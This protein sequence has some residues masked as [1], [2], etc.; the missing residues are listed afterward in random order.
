MPGRRY[1]FRSALLASTSLLGGGGLFAGSAT[2]QVA[3]PTHGVV[4]SGAASIKQS[5]A[6]LTID[7][8]TP[9][10]IINWNS[11]SIGQ[12]ASVTVVQPNA[13]SAQLDRVTGATPSTI[14]GQLRATGQVY[15]VNPNG[16]AITSSGVVRVGGGFVASTLGVTN[17]DF[18]RGVL[19]FSGNGASAAVSNAGSISTAPGGFVGLLGGS[20]SN[21]G[22]ITVP[23]G[24]VG[25]GSGEQATLDPTGDGFLQV[26]VPTGAT[27]SDGTALVDVSGKVS[28][29]GGRV[30]LK[31]ATAAGA[32]R[33]A[34]NLSGVVSATSARV[35]GG[36]IILDGGAGGDV[37]VSGA[38]D[39]SGRTSGGSVRI[40][41][42]NVAL[43]KAK[44]AAVGKTGAGGTITSTAA[45]GLALIGTS[46]NASGATRGGV[47]AIGGDRHGA[48][49]LAN[50]ATTSVDA[51][52]MLRADALVS[53]N[54]GTITVWS[55]T[56]TSFAGQISARGGPQGGDGGSAE[57]SA[58]AATHGV[59]SFT[60]LADLRAP[61]GAVGTLLL[62]P[63]DIVISAGADAGGYFSG[64]TGG[65]PASYTPTATSVINAST[66][67]GL[68]ASA[69]VVV[70]TG[71]AGSAG[72]DA[73]AITALAPL[74]W[75]T[76]NGLTLTAAGAIS[77]DSSI[78]A[79]AGG[80][81]LSA[82]GAISATGAISVGTFVLESGAWSQVTPTL[83]AFAS[84]DFEIASGASFLR[85]TG[86]DGSTAHPYTLVDIY[87]VQ[88]VASLLAD[89]F[90]LA[91]NIDATVT[92]TWNAGAGFIPIGGGEAPFIGVFNGAGH[93]IANLTINQASGY[94]DVGLFG[95]VGDGSGS[96]VVENIGLIGGSV[97]ASGS[98]PYVGALIG[99]NEGS[100]TNGYALGVS[101]SGP[102]AGPTGPSG[103]GGLVG[104]NGGS[105]TDSYATGAITS[106]V[107]DVGGL[108]GENFGTVTSS[109]AKGAVSGAGAGIDVGGLVG[110]NV[111]TIASS[112]ATGAVVGAGSDAFVGGLVGLNNDTDGGGGLVE[113]SFAAG[114]V[115]GSGAG[116]AVGGL[117]GENYFS[118]RTSYAT[119]AVSASGAG[120]FVGGLVG[121]DFGTVA[122]SYWDTQT[123][124]QPTSAGGSGAT[125]L[126]TS[127]LQGALPTG[128]VSVS[129]WATGAGLYPYLTTSFPTGVQAISGF[130]YK[131]AAGATPLASGAA[132]AAYVSADASGVSFGSAT[133]GANG[134][135][136]LFAAKG[137]APSGAD[138]IAYTTADATTGATN[139][140]T[141]FVSAGASNASGNTIDGS[142]LTETTPSL[143]YSGIAA[144]LAS[145]AGADTAALAAIAGAVNLTINATGAS[146][147]VDEAITVPGNLSIATAI[148]TGPTLL[149]FAVKSTGGD[150]TFSDAV[151]VGPDVTVEAPTG[152]VTFG[153][154]VDGDAVTVTGVAHIGGNIT[155]AN[156]AITFSDAIILDA[157][158][159]LD[160]GTATMTFA[161]AI[162]S[163]AGD[164]ASKNFDLTATAGSFSFGGA[165]GATDALGAVSLTSTGAMSLPSISA[166]TIVA[167][168]TG[169]SADLTLKSGSV[170]TASVADGTA[171]TL[172]AG[173]NFINDAGAGAIDLSGAGDPP[174]WVIYAASPTGSSFGGL[175]SGNHAIW[176]TPSGGVVPA[177]GNYYV[178]AFQPTVTFT[179]TNHTTTYSP[180]D[181][182]TAATAYTVSG[183]Q[184]GVTGAYLA[185]T[186]AT[187]YSGAPDVTLLSGAS[188]SLPITPGA[189][190]SAGAYAI[191]LSA[192]T[193]ASASGYAF[194]FVS[195]GSLAVSPEAITITAAPNTKIYDSTTSAA[196]K[197][198]VTSGTLYDTATLTETYA[199]P[200]AGTG[201]TLTP[202]ATI[203]GAANYVVTLVSESTGVIAP[204]PI[205]ITVAPNS[206]TYDGATTAA[207]TPTVTSGTLYDPA[208]L[209]ESYV[210]PNAGAGLELIATATIS[211]AANYTVTLASAYDGVITPE[212][213]TI[214]AAPN[215]K[216]YDSMTSAAATPT[217]TSGTLYDP[218]TLAETYAS[219]NAGSGLTLTPTAAIVGA[220]NYTVTL[221]AENTG[222]I[223][224]EPITITAA[225]NTKIYDSTTSAAA[226][227]TVTAG[228]LYDPATLAETYA[229]A[230]AGT[231]LTLTPTAAISGAGNYTVTI[232]PVS[233]GVI[234]PEPITITAAPNAKT[235]DSTTSAAATPTVTAGT[236]Y[237]PATLAETYASANAGA[238]L[239]LTPTAAIS[240][241]GNY[242][243]T[244]IPVSAGVIT[245]EAITVTAA[246]NTKT[247]DGTTTAAAT[248]T[249]TAGTLYDPAMLSETYAGPNAGAGLT[250]NPTAAI[251]DPGNYTVTLAS[252]NTGVINPR[253]LT[254]SVSDSSALFGTTPT[255]GASTLT[256][257]L[258]GDS[259]SAT[260]GAFNGAAQIA[261]NTAT[262]AGLY[263][264]RVT[265][266]NNPN[267]TIAL[268]GNTPGTLTVY[269]ITGPTYPS[270][271][272]FVSGGPTNPVPSGTLADP[273]VLQAALSGGG[274]VS[275]D[276]GGWSEDLA[277]GVGA[278]VAA[279][280]AD[281]VMPNT[282]AFA[283][284]L[285]ALKALSNATENY[286]R[287][288][289]NG[290]QARPGA[291]QT[292]V[293]DALD[294][295]ADA[296]RKL[297]PRLPAELSNLPN[298]VENAARRVRVAPTKAA[299]VRILKEAIREVH[300]EISLIRADDPIVLRR[301]ARIGD[302]VTGTLASATLS[303]ERASGI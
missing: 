76:A 119:G 227:P 202:T 223:T 1:D 174:R 107:G 185:D 205:T 220:A 151:T 78:S 84:A 152:T 62:D 105:I 169:A 58:N 40:A 59:L 45:K 208:T 154:A 30:E 142:T 150:I 136:Y 66:L 191:D 101:V 159:T 265:G 301:D 155:T 134:Y 272:L 246:P 3:L 112:F 298:V 170:L 263:A 50:A 240:G 285:D 53:G 192:G 37:A 153:G 41:G 79:A 299:A 204:E 231:G 17:A 242:T 133:T 93:T 180:T 29:A 113:T 44:I 145:A 261:L 237:D 98:Q 95:L 254:Y 184:A 279:C 88:G 160:S 39:A 228:T 284:P 118:V 287:E 34:V 99:D 43:T 286:I 269:G 296:L 216:I 281:S 83:P 211:G 122:T 274:S 69:N 302:D 68:L 117:V 164:G 55:D 268:S 189:K 81:T 94:L 161:G 97:V 232:I 100:V 125:G 56:L 200:N 126:L 114:A 2:A 26:A 63:Y 106:A 57:V 251:A 73:G 18:N 110:Y 253:P 42:H 280:G 123:T 144:R 256:G 276:S 239:T 181:T 128:F 104:F 102:T 64:A 156:E 92:S 275:F 137:S 173:L 214:T 90:Q 20:V 149:N 163:A 61:H 85:A 288:C 5:G 168:A 248:P 132:G 33:N 139:A 300:K 108:V 196:A 295:Y 210:S 290:A 267:Y 259:V 51:G 138:V 199:S 7:Q 193:L 247:Y 86:G 135:Y 21:S 120:A 11:F 175:D 158:V 187:A 121:N 143:L 195:S 71:A 294:R 255:L 194:A 115:L 47:I 209:K 234:T 147:T 206:K 283:D 264:E 80:L 179:S 46:V 224:P 273:T 236:L 278:G 16:I 70:S 48:G 25:L 87:G 182:A 213:I 36:A 27:T 124:G 172:S 91:G 67:E 116:V 230:N 221:A 54:G 252:T 35:R 38:I 96:G 293:A 24:K 262:L 282:D 241:A 141:Y 109:Y 31:A 171:V 8:T 198:T 49:P 131:D 203:A 297:T 245:P 23:L 271:A 178:F 89:N 177:T 260:A 250:L 4:A 243:V 201:L 167:S 207:A 111:G 190:A 266:L 215:T 244:I 10:A 129:P 74:T 292:N 22:T 225:P 13:A 176:D 130:A 238:G 197:P 162:D 32:I 146:F 127:Q 249:V 218:A 257:V 217:V 148:A 219:P 165:I 140:A 103:L 258:P 222:G 15:L 12:G 72:S 188:G 289:H 303:L 235:Y 291:T 14:A 233:A 166:A 212:P 65:E 52:S 6:H 77:L 19:S 229:S 157:N 277:P 183:V 9:R 75:S 226:K 270:P 28:A 60:G 82:G 186:A